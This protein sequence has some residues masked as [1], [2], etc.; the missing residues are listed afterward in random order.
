MDR[1]SGVEEM[2]EPKLVR[3]QKKPVRSARVLTRSARTGS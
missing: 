2:Q 3:A 1:R